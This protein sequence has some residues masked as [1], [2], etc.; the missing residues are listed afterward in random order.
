MPNYGFALPPAF[1]PPLFMQ[2]RRKRL[3]N[4]E[5]QCNIQ[6]PFEESERHVENKQAFQKSVG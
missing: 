4:E 6:Q 1:L 3:V 5:A 2:Q